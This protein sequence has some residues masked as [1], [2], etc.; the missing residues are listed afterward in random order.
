MN[1]EGHAEPEDWE[2]TTCEDSGQPFVE[3]Y[4]LISFHTVVNFIM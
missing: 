3:A 1:E 4:V 2:P